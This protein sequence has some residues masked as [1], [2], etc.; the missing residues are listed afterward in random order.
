M[1][2]HGLKITAGV[3]VA[4]LLCS[5]ARSQTQLWST[6]F[7]GRLNEM[8]SASVAT[9]DGG[10]AVL[11]STYSFGSGGMD[12][13]LV[14][15]DSLGDTLWTRTF[16]GASFEDGYDI[17]RTADGGFVMVG[18]TESYGGGGRDIYL[19]RADSSGRVLWA[20]TYGG[21]Q[22]DEGMSVRLTPDGG[23]VICG[24]TCSFGSGYNDVYFVRTNAAG[25][26]VW[27]RTFG[28]PGGDSGFAVRVTADGGFIAVGTTGSFGTGYSSVYAIRMDSDGD[29]LWATTYGGTRADIGYSLE[30]TSDGGFIFVGASA[31]FGA[32]YN[33]AYLV[34]TDIAGNVTWEYIYGGTYDDRGYS[35][36]QTADG[37]YALVGSTL[38]F[39]S[40]KNDVYVVKVDPMGT[41]IWSRSYGG[42]ESDFCHAVIEDSGLDLFLVGHSYSYSAGGS[43]IYMLKIKGSDA[44]PV[45]EIDRPGLPDGFVL[46]QNY[47]NP[48]NPS[49]TIEFSVPGRS[50][51][52]LTI[53]NVLGQIV[54]QWQFSSLSAGT[55]AVEWDGC[56]DGGRGVASGVYFYRLDAG[57]TSQTKKMLLLK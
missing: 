54:R 6:N 18:A 11:G 12:F 22:D 53:F 31:S 49:T 16:G 33:D 42:R 14:K 52:F 45:Y 21:G 40:G 5:P 19:V 32:S 43:D 34:K 41:E 2:R 26:T 29:S 55:Y 17:Q 8:G 25:D 48:F 30:L 9:A 10:F 50:R 24:T 28:G 46:A 36:C 38:S 27:T 3:I 13:Y 7:G 15:I 37:G 23:Y 39:G 44:T 4:G 51:A 47:P 35:V 20:R 1:A 56:N 57:A